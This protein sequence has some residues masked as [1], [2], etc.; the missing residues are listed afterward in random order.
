MKNISTSN[1]FLFSLA[2]LF[3]LKYWIFGSLI[4]IAIDR[5]FLFYCMNVYKMNSLL[6]AACMMM[7]SNISH[8]GFRDLN[9]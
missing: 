3:G 9:Q 4:N 1:I 8:V 5:E 6:F 7:S 2:F